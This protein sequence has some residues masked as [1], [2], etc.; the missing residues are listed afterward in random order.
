VLREAA[1]C[2]GL[3]LIRISGAPVKFNPKFA[4]IRPPQL[5]ERIPE[6]RRVRL[7]SRIALRIANQHTDPP[8]L[9]GLLRPRRERPRGCAA[10][11]RDEIAAPT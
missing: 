2:E 5:R 3:Y 7:H 11:Q 8:Y 10:E 4:A 9:L 6:C 1:F